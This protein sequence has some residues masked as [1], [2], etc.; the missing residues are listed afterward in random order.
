M[1][2]DVTKGGY[3]MLGRCGENLARTIEIDVSEY[4]KNYPG[5][6]V[7]LLHRRHGENNIY[8]VAAELRDGCLVWRPT[9]ADTAIVGEGEAEV[10]VTVHGVLAKSKIIS[11]VVSRSLT[12]QETDAPEPSKDWVDRVINAV[13][14][15]QQMTAEAESVAY[16]EPATATYDGETGTMRFGIPEGKPGKDGTDG[17]DGAPGAKGDK[18]DRGERGPQGEPGIDAE[19]TADNIQS[20][21]GYAPVSP[22]S[23]A[24]KQDTL[25]DADRQSITKTGMT[26]GAAWTA[27]E[28]KAARDKFGIPGNYELLQSITV[29]EGGA[30]RVDISSFPALSRIMAC[31]TLQKV[32]SFDFFFA[33]MLDTN[34]TYVAGTSYGNAD[35]PVSIRFAVELDG[36]IAMAW[37]CGTISGWGGGP[38]IGPNSAGNIVTGNAIVGA[39]LYATKNDVIPEGT[40]IKIYG[41]KV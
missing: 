38:M 5:G 25:T 15:V 31:V 39:Y 11:T 8:P 10:R 35:Y 41:V 26:T 12:G 7:T 37:S 16:G 3:I 27:A 20:A 33:V 24:A 14:S 19:V 9:S 28:Q 30:S 34:R 22:A 36:G 6:V 40:T 18:G 23:L 32:T 17:K 1:K 29:G 13:G 21:L 4:L 2:Y